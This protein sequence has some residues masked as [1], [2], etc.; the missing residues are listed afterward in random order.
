[1][2][3]RLDVVVL[4][5]GGSR[6]MGRDK[7]LLRLDGDR[8]V[9]RMADR[10]GAVAGRVFVASGARPLGRGDEVAD[11]A[12]CGGPLAGVLAVL[13]VSQADL[14]GVVPV[15]APYT[16]P[17]VLVRLAELCDDH[18]RAAAVATVDG[19]VQ[20]LH[21]VLA[22]DAAAAVEARVAAGERSPRRLLGWLDALRV[23][24]QGWGDLDRDGALARDWDRPADL[25]VGLR[26]PG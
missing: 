11:A 22:T 26:R 4:A 6:R 19:H 9:D 25:P 20:A 8:L 14:I 15:D 10:M 24:V 23:D 13:R 1:M 18:G 5:G 3:A 2:S 17:R 16:D 12:G 21:A 7:A